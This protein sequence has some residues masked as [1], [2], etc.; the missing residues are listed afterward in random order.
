M[1]CVIYLFGGEKGV[2]LRENREVKNCFLFVL[3]VLGIFLSIGALIT[4]NVRY[5]FCVI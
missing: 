4:K 1:S 3:V 2:K 5:G